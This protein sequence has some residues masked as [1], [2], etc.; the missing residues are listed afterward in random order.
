VALPNG[1][2]ALVCHARHPEDADTV[3]ALLAGLDGLDLTEPFA[4]I[5]EAIGEARK[6]G[7]TNRA[8]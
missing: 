7:V 3:R 2:G 6:L 8:A 5:R 4:R 1:R